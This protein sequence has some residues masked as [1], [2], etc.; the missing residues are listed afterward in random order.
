M[1]EVGAGDPLHHHRMEE[2]V[3]VE[4]PHRREEVVGEEPL[5]RMEQGEVEV[6]DP[7]HLLVEVGVEPPL[8]M[9]EVVEPPLWMEEVVEPPLWMKEVVGEEPLH[10][11][12]QV[13]VALR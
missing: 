6:G 13:Q 3:G 5:H 12:E 2:V 10:R 11:M 1:E 7:L 8:W 4:P 9:E